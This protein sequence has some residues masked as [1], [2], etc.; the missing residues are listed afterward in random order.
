MK[1][2]DKLRQAKDAKE[3]A[4]LICEAPLCLLCDGIEKMGV[5]PGDCLSATVKWLESEAES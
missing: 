3:M 4:T 1:N 5:C 2:K